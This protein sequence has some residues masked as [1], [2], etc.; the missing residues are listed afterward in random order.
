MKRK[1]LMF[2]KMIIWMFGV[3]GVVCLVG[4]YFNPSLMYPAIICGVLVGKGFHDIKKNKDG[5]Y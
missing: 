4:I 3:L 2:A 5:S 1:D